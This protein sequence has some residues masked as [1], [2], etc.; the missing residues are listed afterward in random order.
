MYIGQ[1]MFNDVDVF[2]RSKGFDL[3]D[4]RKTYWNCSLGSGADKGRLIFG[5]ALYFRSPDSLLEAVKVGSKDAAY[6]QRG[7]AVYLA[8]GYRRLAS[9][10]VDIARAEGLLT[11]AD[12]VH[13]KSLF[14]AYPW[15]RQARFPMHKLKSL[16]PISIKAKIKSGLGKYFGFRHPGGKIGN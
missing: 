7:I 16:V 2:L 6:I 15:N 11:E 8:Y 9:W 5:D 14:N 3:F 1:P 4:L 10:T 13:C 12:E